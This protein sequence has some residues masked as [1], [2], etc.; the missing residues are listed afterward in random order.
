VPV[1]VYASIAAGGLDDSATVK[2]DSPAWVPKGY[3]NCYG[4]RVTG[5]SMVDAGIDPDD[6]LIVRLST[7]AREERIV[8]ALIDNG[9]TVKRYR[10][11]H[12]EPVLVAE[13]AGHT[14]IPASD[15]FKLQGVVL[16]IFK[17]RR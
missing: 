3:A 11:I 13:G 9:A 12:G 7:R 8:V 5:T 15:G 16:A 2:E 10:Q 1:T 14:N 4:L 17:R 6:I